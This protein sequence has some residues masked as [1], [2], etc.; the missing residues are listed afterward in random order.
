MRS[1]V[2]T[3]DFER[4]LATGGEEKG[5]TRSNQRG[6][7]STRSNQGGKGSTRSNQRGKGST[8]FRHKENRFHKYPKSQN[9]KGTHLQ[10]VTARIS[11]LPLRIKN[12]LVV[13][14][15]SQGLPAY[16]LIALN[17]SKG[18]YIALIH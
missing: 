18:D 12:K 5:S 7:G 6:K 13:L 16:L 3:L 4:Q 15:V 9:M 14:N 17:L 11:R 10:H 8:R 2:A 1:V